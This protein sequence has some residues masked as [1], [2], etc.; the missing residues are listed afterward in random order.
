MQVAGIFIYSNVEIHLHGLSPLGASISKF[1]RV[2]Y[3]NFIT[4][5][6]EC[7]YEKKKLFSLVLEKLM[8][9]GH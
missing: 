5:Q 2:L 6:L 7:K 4:V 9:K 1:F 8:F 3:F